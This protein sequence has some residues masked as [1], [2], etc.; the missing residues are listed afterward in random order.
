LEGWADRQALL[1]CELHRRAQQVV[2]ADGVQENLN[3]S[4]GVLRTIFEAFLVDLGR[5]RC[6]KPVVWDGI[7]R[8]LFSFAVPDKVEGVHG[9]IVSLLVVFGRLTPVEA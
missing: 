6:A 7:K 9:E 5:P 4:S 1:V 3:R 2:N 8:L